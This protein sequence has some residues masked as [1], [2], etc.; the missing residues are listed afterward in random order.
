MAAR[1]RIN[2]ERLQTDGRSS[3]T[4][5]NSK[6]IWPPEQEIRVLRGPVVENDELQG[7]VRWA[8]PPRARCAPRACFDPDNAL[9][10]SPRGQVETQFMFIYVS[11]CCHGRCCHRHVAA[12]TSLPHRW[13]L[14]NQCRCSG[15]PAGYQA[16]SSAQ[17]CG[18]SHRYCDPVAILC[19]PCCPS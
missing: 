5:P 19:H 7:S 11:A 17:M 2:H 8:C 16:C 3:G 6:G 4:A 9:H 15:S 18:C 10:S 13:Q 14:V 1:V 12:S